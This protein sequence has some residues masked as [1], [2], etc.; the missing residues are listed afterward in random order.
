MRIG[1]KVH[2]TD[3]ANRKID[4][5]DGAGVKEDFG[6]RLYHCIVYLSM[7]GNDTVILYIHIQ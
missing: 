3:F 4:S 6:S 5:S 7:R 2:E 1:G